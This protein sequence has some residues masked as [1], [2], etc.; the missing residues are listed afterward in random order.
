MKQ[1]KMKCKTSKAVPTL[2]E[3]EIPFDWLG[4]FPVGSKFIGYVKSDHG[5]E[6]IAAIAPA[7]WV[8]DD[9]ASIGDEFTIRNFYGENETC[10][11][12]GDTESLDLSLEYLSETLKLTPWQLNQLF[13]FDGKHKDLKKHILKIIARLLPT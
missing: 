8:D 7:K 11:S 3:S 12:G 1:N 10:L 6:Y 9:L 13:R 5:G 2:M 4:Q